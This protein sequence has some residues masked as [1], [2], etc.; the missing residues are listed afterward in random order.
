MLTAQSTVQR[1]RIAVIG[2]GISGLAAAHRLLELQPGVDL[3]VFEAGDRCGGV[4]GTEDIDGFRVELGPDSMLKALPWGVGLCKRLGI[5]EQLDSTDTQNHQTWILRAGRL[6]PL[7]EDLAIMAP[8]RLWPTLRSPILSIPAKLRMACEWFIRRRAESGDESLAEFAR[9]RF[10]RETFERLI[11]PLVS[12]I[13]MA[14]PEK[15]SMRAALPRF[16]DM[17]AEHGSLIRAARRA[18]REQQ[19]RECAVTVSASN[20]KTSGMFVAPRTGLGSLIDAIG[21]RL[22]DGAIRLRTPVSALTRADDGGWMVTAR[23]SGSEYFDGVIVATPSG[24]AAR[25]L[26]RENKALAVELDAIAHSGC[27]VVTLAYTRDDIRHPLNGHGFV[28]PQVE[29][30]EMIACT[31]SSVKY[32]HRAPAGQVLLRVYLGG[33]TRPQV[34]NYDD[35]KLLSVVATELNPLLGIRGQPTLTRIQR[36]PNVIPQ[37]YVGHLDRMKRI[38]AEVARLPGIELAGNSYRGVGI[39]HCIHSGEQAAERVLACVSQKKQAVFANSGDLMKPSIYTSDDF[40][41]QPLMLYYEVTQACD[42]VCRHCRA[43]AQPCAPPGELTTEQSRS[44]IDQAATF[45]KPPVMVFTGGDPLKRPDLFELIR[46]ASDSGIQVALTPSAT[47]LATPDMFRQA[48]D[49]GVARLGI[50]L[51]GANAETHD[52]F[53]GWRGSFDRTLKMIEDARWIDMPVQINTSITR[54]NFHQIDE[55]AE[56]L[57]DRGIAMWSVFF[58]VPVGRGVEEERIS[59]KEYEVAFEKLFQQS[60]RQPFGIKTTEAPH[61]R[62]FVMRRNADPLAEPLNGRYTARGKTY[63]APLGVRDGRGI[64]FVSHTGEIYPAGFLPLVCGTFP[65]DSIVNVYQNHPMFVAMRDGS[66]LRGKCGTCDYNDVCG[67]SR[68][69]AFAVTGDPLAAEPDCVYSGHESAMN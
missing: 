4:I 28:V 32:A 14:D 23:D 57:S 59:A 9:R 44:L 48:K 41:I 45:P 22:P 64:M 27:V 55:I 43:S 19:R 46:Y 63:R 42:L 31:F 33:A 26:I 47:P 36:W 18:V 49:A 29:N 40:N 38:D 56:L 12:G 25:L 53:R 6:Q 15:L 20:A 2:G 5:A 54:R 58:L 7:P 61:Y 52:A 68:S 65:Q 51:D 69:R 66:R 50:S 21:A 16:V 67:G 37:Y 34:L 39:P 11:Q 8:R 62:R 10:G 35:D 30:R 1:Q 60:Q 24:T 17:E 3:T 13:Y